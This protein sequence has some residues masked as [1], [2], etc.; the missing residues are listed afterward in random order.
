LPRLRENT[1]RAEENV[2]AAVLALLSSLGS[3]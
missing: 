3:S 1:R 2:T